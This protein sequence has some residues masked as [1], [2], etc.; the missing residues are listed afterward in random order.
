MAVQTNGGAEPAPKADKPKGKSL[1][2]ELKA[3]YWDHKGGRH[4]VGDVVSIP[5]AAAK[6]LV[7]DDKAKLL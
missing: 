1:K 3:D 2:V 5:E 7:N 6:S 4:F